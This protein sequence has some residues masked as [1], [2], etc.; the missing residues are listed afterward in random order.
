MVA[1][2]QSLISLLAAVVLPAHHQP[3]PDRSG[4]PPARP[5]SLPLARFPERRP[6]ASS[7]RHVAA[8]RNLRRSR[9]PP[10]N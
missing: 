3:G 10:A 6:R 9:W 4:M 8:R 2:R 7:S 1:K 5:A